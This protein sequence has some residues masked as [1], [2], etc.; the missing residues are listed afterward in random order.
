MTITVIAVLG[1]GRSGSTLLDVLL[2]QHPNVAGVGE[3]MQLHREGWQLNNYC[4]CGARARDCPFWAEVRRLWTARSGI[5]SIEEY[6]DLQRRFL[7]PS[8]LLSGTKAWETDD[9]VRFLRATQAI[10]ET[11]SEVSG[12]NTIVDSSKLPLWGLLASRLPGIR[13][14]AVH[15][16]RDGRGVAHSLGKAYATDTEAGV[17]ID[18]PARPVW[19]SALSWAYYNLFTEYVIASRKIPAVRLCYEDLIAC[20][21]SALARIGALAG[22]NFDEVTDWIESGGGV[23]P[24]HMIAGNRLR[25]QSG[26]TLRRDLEW[27]QRMTLGQELCF[28]SLAGPVALRYGYRPRTARS[29]E[30]VPE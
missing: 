24:G 7:R 26:V 30:L 22:A 29:R 5:E 27:R 1:Y 23:A 17:Q 19:R 16:V 6:L 20:P 13:L 28:W 21:R 8:T 3:L 10:Y 11:V 14:R 9:A 18:I 25:M 4:A 2:G 15:L 12:N